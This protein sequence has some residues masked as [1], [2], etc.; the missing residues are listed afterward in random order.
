MSHSRSLEKAQPFI[1][2]LGHDMAAKL[3]IK[4]GG[5][6]LY[7]AQSPTAQSTFVKELGY[8]NTLKLA[9]KLGSG[10]VKIPI[11]KLW[12]AKYYVENI[13]MSKSAAGRKIRVDEA[14]I[15]RWLSPSANQNQLSLFD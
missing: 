13:G 1:T 6:T 12:L 8:D 11:A 10:N 14:T 9:Q 2:I 5:S 7:L 4:Y 3:F 15:R